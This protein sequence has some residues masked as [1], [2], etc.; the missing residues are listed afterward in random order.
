MSTILLYPT[1]GGVDPILNNTYKDGNR[2]IQYIVRT[3]TTLTGLGRITSV[4]K[5]KDSST[6]GHVGPSA[7]NSHSQVEY[8][9]DAPPAPDGRTS[10]N[11][12][13]APVVAE[14]QKNPGE[15]ETIVEV[16]EERMML[17]GNI[18]WNLFKSSTIVFRDEPELEADHYFRK[19][20]W[21]WWGR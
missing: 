15:K 8:V 7:T 16:E 5:S 6:K 10:I 20:S 11:L 18:G 19:E 1:F 17:V 2:T 12:D 14:E 9:E 3:P 4:F 21:G 13:E